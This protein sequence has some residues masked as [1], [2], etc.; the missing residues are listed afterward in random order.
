MII[1]DGTFGDKT[2]FTNLAKSFELAHCN[3]LL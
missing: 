3:N 1:Q 2:W